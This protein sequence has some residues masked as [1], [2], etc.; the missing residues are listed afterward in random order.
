MLVLEISESLR[1]RVDFRHPSELG[2][3]DE[4]I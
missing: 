4:A 1:E 3:N 2:V